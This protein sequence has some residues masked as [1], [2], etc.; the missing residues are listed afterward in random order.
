MENGDGLFQEKQLKQ[1]VLFITLMCSVDGLVHETEWE[2]IQSFVNNYW[3]TDYSSFMKYQK[4]LFDEISMLLNDEERYYEKIDH[5]IEIFAEQFSSEQ[6][7]RVMD[8]IE[9]LVTSDSLLALEETYIYNS[10]M[11][12]LDFSSP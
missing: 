4:E 1:V 6:K 3:Q 7:S 2:S 11:K 8:L 10:L 9:K 12:R 5:L